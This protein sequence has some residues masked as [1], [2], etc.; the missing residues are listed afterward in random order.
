[1]NQK[2]VNTIISTVLADYDC[3]TLMQ[4]KSERIRDG[5]VPVDIIA[6]LQDCALDIRRA[7]AKRGRLPNSYFYHWARLLDRIADEVKSSTVVL[8]SK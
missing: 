6:A 8:P 5:L 3:D 4:D 7:T 2:L 1:M